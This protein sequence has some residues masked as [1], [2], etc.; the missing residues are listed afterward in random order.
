MDV[1]CP[2]CGFYREI[3]DNAIPATA[4]LAT[5]PKCQHK[6]RFREDEPSEAAAPADEGFGFESPETGQAAAPRRD[7]P[8]PPPHVTPSAPEREHPKEPSAAGQ[9]RKEQPRD[10]WSSLEDM[11]EPADKGDEGDEGGPNQQ[12]GQPLGGPSYSRTFDRSHLA[13]GY[14][15]G[16]GEVPWEN[17]DQYGFFGGLFDTIRQAMLRP[18][19]FFEAMPVTGGMARP[20]LFYTLCSEFAA[21]IGYF[22]ERMGLTLMGMGGLGGESIGPATPEAA[23]GAAPNWGEIFATGLGE[24][25]LQV[26]L[27][28]LLVY[29]LLFAVG[30]MISTAIFHLFLMIFQSA[31]G[32]FEGTFRA[33]SYANAPAVLA[34]IPLLGP[35]AAGLWGMVLIFIG[36]SRAH[37]VGV[38]R[39]IAAF[40][41]PIVVLAVGFAVIAIALGPGIG[42]G[43]GGATGSGGA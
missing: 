6:F 42:G 39:V 30:L 31:S 19:S 25:S 7:E 40:I 8:E 15:S 35:V 16:R 14:D 20:L 5:C 41:V 12:H 38:L 28:L 21:I 34:A 26:A 9:A 33:L 10:L 11:G 2:Q 29:P 36:L 37:R 1:T 3:P 4:K 13:G 18:F 24:P 22:W 32:G 43:I 17:L 23:T 27:I